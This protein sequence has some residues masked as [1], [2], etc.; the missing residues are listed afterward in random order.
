MTSVKGTIAG[1]RT[2][3]AVRRLKAFRKLGVEGSFWTRRTNVRNNVVWIVV[4]VREEGHLELRD[5]QS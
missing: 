5:S 2:A 4:T 3:A 1:I